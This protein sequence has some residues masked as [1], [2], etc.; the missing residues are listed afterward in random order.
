MSR[1]IL[2]EFGPDAHKPQA[3]RAT[4]G[5]PTTAKPIPYS[6]PQGPQG[7]MKEGVGLGGTNAGCGQRFDPGSRGGSPGIGGTNHG[8]AGSQGRR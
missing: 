5:G 7:I 8:N 6:P 1:P 4:S 3:P 2:S